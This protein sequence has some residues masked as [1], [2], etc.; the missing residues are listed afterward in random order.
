MK[1]A[2]AA[3]AF[4]GQ[5]GLAISMPTYCFRFMLRCLTINFSTTNI[6]EWRMVN[7]EW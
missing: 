1:A 6:R 2:A 5:T 7:G 3:T 4:Q